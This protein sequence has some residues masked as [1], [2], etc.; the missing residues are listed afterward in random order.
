MDLV[1]G[2]G[3]AILKLLSSID[4]SLLLWWDVF[5]VFDLVTNVLDDVC[6]FDIE[7]DSLASE[8]LDEDLHS[9]SQYEDEME[10]YS[11]GC[12]SR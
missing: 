3:S 10:G 6:W 5:V 11:F 2:E 7:G 4:E 8:G 12:C 1:D 9:T